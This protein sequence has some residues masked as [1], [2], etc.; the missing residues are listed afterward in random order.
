MLRSAERVPWLLCLAAFA[1]LCT[2]LPA[3]SRTVPVCVH[4]PF[5]APAPHPPKVPALPATSDL[6]NRTWCA[7]CEANFTSSFVGTPIFESQLFPYR[8]GEV[9]DLTRIFAIFDAHEAS[10]RVGGMLRLITQAI[11]VPY[12]DT[13]DERRWVAHMYEQPPGATERYPGYHFVHFF[14]VWASTRGRARGYAG[15]ELIQLFAA[16][17]PQPNL[18][19]A[20]LHGVVW[21]ATV[22]YGD[23][24][25]ARHVSLTAPMTHMLFWHVAHG[26]GHGALMRIMTR[27]MAQ[28]TVPVQGLWTVDSATLDAALRLCDAAPTRD[29]AA[30]CAQ[31]LFHG[32]VHLQHGTTDVAYCDG[33]PWWSRLACFNILA[34]PEHRGVDLDPSFCR[35]RRD[36]RTRRACW[37]VL[38][39]HQFPYFQSTA[40]RDTDGCVLWNAIVAAPTT[41]Q[42]WQQRE[43]GDGSSP[44]L[45]WCAYVSTQ[46]RRANRF[47]LLAA[48]VH[49]AAFYVNTLID[50]FGLDM[51]AV[52]PYCES[53]RNLDDL[54]E[55]RLEWMVQFCVEQ[56]LRETERGVVAG[57]FRAF[58]PWVYMP[59]D[60]S[61]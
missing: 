16:A 17:S 30:A 2:D 19:G 35:A 6:L 10:L 38:T 18:L 23:A 5:G 60:S 36:E 28:P 32:A 51:H 45:Q 54:D 42:W 57:E 40:L 47:Y 58:E 13:R 11:T 55:S 52:R 24:V 1:G 50:H 25:W 49:G 53:L 21:D 44:L 56:L 27:G 7:A 22:A 26:V 61:P 37:A 43:W 8:N 48:C 34:R 3:A 9:Y 31:G 29:L 59:L 15:E 41:T 39:I 46:D 4:T 12:Y 14:G 20:F 33:A